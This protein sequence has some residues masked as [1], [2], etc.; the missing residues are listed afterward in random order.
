M[1]LGPVS[2]FGKKNTATSKKFDV[3]VMSANR[4]VIVIFPIYK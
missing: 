2:K 4:N 1:K 3:E